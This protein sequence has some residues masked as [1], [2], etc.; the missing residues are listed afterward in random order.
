MMNRT[1]RPEAVHERAVSRHFR[2]VP[3]GL[4]F[5]R[6]EIKTRQDFPV[7]DYLPPTTTPADRFCAEHPRRIRL[8]GRRLAVEHPE[9]FASVMTLALAVTALV[10]WEMCR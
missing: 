3:G 6:R 2:C 4:D 10:V 9:L 1:R 8:W 7:T 5:R